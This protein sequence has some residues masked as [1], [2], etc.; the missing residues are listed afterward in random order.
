LCGFLPFDAEDDDSLIE[1]V[2]EGIYTFPSPVWD[3]ISE[4]AKDL[5]T[6]LLEKDPAKRITAKQLLQHPWL[7]SPGVGFTFLFR[8]RKFE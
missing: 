3:S 8:L 6:R 7:K 1:L 5:V 4:S 2:K